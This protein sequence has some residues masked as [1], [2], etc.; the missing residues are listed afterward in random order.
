MVP[1]DLDADRPI[2]ERYV[3]HAPG[4]SEE[5]MPDLSAL[6]DEDWFGEGSAFDSGEDLAAALMAMAGGGAS[7]EAAGGLQFA[8][9][10][11]DDAISRGA[12]VQEASHGFAFEPTRDEE[13]VVAPSHGEEV[14]SQTAPTE[15]APQPG[16]HPQTLKARRSGQRDWTFRNGILAM[17]K[18]EDSIARMRKSAIEVS[19]VAAGVVLAVAD[20]AKVPH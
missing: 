2:Q 19:W 6:D 11:P 7:P 13:V 5:T 20:Q 14:G 9:L 3:A 1:P 12:G 10:S 4:S 15:E 17:R 8:P 18:A 16:W